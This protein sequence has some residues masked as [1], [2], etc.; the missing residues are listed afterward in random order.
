MLLPIFSGLKSSLKSSALGVAALAAALG[1]VSC[2]DG[3]S[4][5]SD[6]SNTSD[7]V[8][9]AEN[10][11]ASQANEPLPIVVATNGILCDLTEQVAQDTVDLTCLLEPGQDPHTYSPSPSDRKAIEDA[12]LVLY[13]GYDSE[14]SVQSLVENRDRAVAVF[15]AAVPN[16]LMGEKHSHDHGH[17]HSDEHAHDHSNDHD[18][19]GEADH[20]HEDDPD[21]AHGEEEAAAAGDM[22]PDPHVWHDAENGIAMVNTIE[23]SLATAFPDQ[24]AMYQQNAEALNA[25]LAQIDQWI[26]DQVATVPERDRNLVTIH[27]AFGYYADA[28]GFSVAGA[29]SGLSTEEKPS[30]ARITDMVNLVKDANVPAIFTETTANPQLI[31]TVARDADV[32]VAEKPLFV[33][34]PGGAGTDAPTYQ[35]MLVT[36]TCTIVNALGGTCS[37]DEAPVTE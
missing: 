33:E 6:A 7:M 9:A 26:Q 36:N 31:E 2:S 35:Q 21:H 27:D 32:Q 18:H 25:Q 30:A 5:S 3:P 10:E 28:Y 37:Q 17:D 20:A 14:P 16:P 15:E 22:A 13:G 8:D 19:S 29:L 12:D 11:T 34:G 4:A 23:D 24:A 1:L